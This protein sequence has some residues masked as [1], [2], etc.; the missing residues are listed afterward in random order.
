MNNCESSTNVCNDSMNST[1]KRIKY[2][3]EISKTSNDIKFNAQQRRF[4][5]QQ[6]QRKKLETNVI[7]TR[8]QDKKKIKQNEKQ[9]TQTRIQQTI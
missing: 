7:I 4:N 9:Q 6:Q 5:E 2:E 3:I 8:N 1:S